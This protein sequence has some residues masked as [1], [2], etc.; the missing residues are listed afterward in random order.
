MTTGRLPQRHPLL[1]VLVIGGA[2]LLVFEVFLMMGLAIPLSPS[3]D[4][5]MLRHF[6]WLG[7]VALILAV[8][9]FGSVL[10]VY[11]GAT[12]IAG[13][14]LLVAAAVSAVGA[15]LATA[16]GIRLT[17]ALFAV[18]AVCQLGGGLLLRRLGN[19]GART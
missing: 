4:I 12:R 17:V 16:T 13:N 19:A 9:L 5:G 3:E 10:R 18:F 1:A 14:S 6:G 8:M 7:L 15:G 2:L 11:V